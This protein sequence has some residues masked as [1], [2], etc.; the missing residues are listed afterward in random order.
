ME[1]L[2]HPSPLVAFINL[3][4]AP[5][6]IR[7]ADHVVFSALITLTILVIGLIVRKSL[8]VENPGKFMLL[9]EWESMDAHIAFPKNPVYGEFRQLIGSFSK[10][11]AMEHFEMD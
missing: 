4:L 8:S 11:G 7:A 6:H 3:L 1:A 10:G 9:V 2:E 5:L